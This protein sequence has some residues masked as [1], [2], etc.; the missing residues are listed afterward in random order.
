MFE[1]GW[2]NHEIQAPIKSL[3]DAKSELLTAR[4]LRKAE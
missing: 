2:R 4:K 3:E 1:R